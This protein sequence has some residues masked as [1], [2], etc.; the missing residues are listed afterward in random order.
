MERTRRGTSCKSKKLKKKGKTIP[1]TGLGGLYVCEMLRIAHCL[2]NRLTDGG[3]VLSF[4]IFT[5]FL[6]RVLIYVRG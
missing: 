2:D 6:L 3:K 5:I 1:V 4:I